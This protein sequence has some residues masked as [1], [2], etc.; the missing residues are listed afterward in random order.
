MEMTPEQYTRAARAMARE[1]LDTVAQ[2]G[3]SPDDTANLAG[4]AL[5]EV[6]GQQLGKF[7]AANR[8][9]DL[10]DILEKEAFEEPRL[11]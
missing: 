3:L 11:N 1:F 10:A 9:R 2:V 5:A 7:G 8:L 6:I 4:A